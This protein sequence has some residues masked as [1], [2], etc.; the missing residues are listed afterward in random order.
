M[1]ES[2]NHPDSKGEMETQEAWRSARSWRE[3]VTA[4]EVVPESTDEAAAEPSHRLIASVSRKAGRLFQ[5]VAF[6]LDLPF[7]VPETFKD[8]PTV[9][10]NWEGSED[11]YECYWLCVISLFA[12][13]A[14]IDVHN[15]KLRTINIPKN[16]DGKVCWDEYLD[17]DRSSDPQILQLTQQTK[18]HKSVRH[19]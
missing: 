5:K 15:P 7:T 6:Q 3:I 11:L 19:Q 17:P 12:K 4:F 9:H 14:M 8:P 1:Q 13:E 16:R 18:S 2:E 10:P